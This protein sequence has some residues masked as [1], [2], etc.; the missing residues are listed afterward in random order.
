MASSTAYMYA[1]HVLQ[2][3]HVRSDSSI[4]RIGIGDNLVKQLVLFPCSFDLSHNAIMG[5]HTPYEIQPTTSERKDM[6]SM[7]KDRL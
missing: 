4:H 6:E 1:V 5:A 7:P 3:S 2:F